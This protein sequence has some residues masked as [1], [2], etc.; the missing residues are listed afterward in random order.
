MGKLLFTFI[1]LAFAWTCS[2]AIVVVKPGTFPTM[3]Q[4]GGYVTQTTPIVIKT[5]AFNDFGAGDWEAYEVGAPAGYEFSISTCTITFYG[6]GGGNVSLPSL[7]VGNYN[8]LFVVI[9]IDNP[10]SM[11][12]IVISG[13]Q[14]RALVGATSPA[15]I[16][17]VAATDYAPTPDH[18]E[19]GNMPAN[20]LLH[21]V[22]TSVPDPIPTITF[23]PQPYYCNLENSNNPLTATPT[24][25]TWS[26]TGV[27]SNVFN[28]YTVSPNTYTLTYSVLN[29]GFCL[30]QTTV[31]VVVKSS[32]TVTMTSS[33]ADNV[34]CVGQSVTFT[35]SST[36]TNKR[37]QFLKNNIP[38][39]ALSTTNIYTTTTLLNNDQITVVSDNGNFTCAD[40]SSVITMTVISNPN[41]TLSITGLPLLV[42]SNNTNSY[43]IVVSPTGLGTI[44]GSGVSGT[45]FTPSAASAGMQTISYN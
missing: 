6:A 30:N 19:N 5:T 24:S 17:R 39:T 40:T 13:L 10:S 8:L 20:M 43:P 41:A 32:P 25:G 22:L 14:V 21:G 7:G 45:N 38:I 2:K 15:N 44:T 16:Y 4:G 34:I 3:C 42:C 36:G 37:Y 1:L 11:D 12:S 29:G 31:D 23:S 18:I 27:T 9:S 35:G 33:D 26:G 28:P